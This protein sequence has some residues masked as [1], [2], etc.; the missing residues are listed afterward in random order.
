[1]FAI[2]A[3]SQYGQAFPPYA[4]AVLGDSLLLTALFNDT[5]GSV[6]LATS[7]HA[8]VN[9]STVLDPVPPDVL[10]TAGFPD[11]VMI[12]MGLSVWAVALVVIARHG[13][14]PSSQ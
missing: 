2:P 13:W 3:S 12:G 8:G 1:M 7:F 9:A 6:L 11:V 14:A 4:V 10:R 5:G